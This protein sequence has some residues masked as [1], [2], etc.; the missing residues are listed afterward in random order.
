[1]LTIFNLYDR[2]MNNIFIQVENYRRC[3]LTYVRIMQ[4]GQDSSKRK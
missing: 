3:H 1:M 2:K 4:R